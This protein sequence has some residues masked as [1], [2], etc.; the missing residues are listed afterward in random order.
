MGRTSSHA[1]A[2]TRFF[3]RSASTSSSALRFAALAGRGSVSSS[4]DADGGAGGGGGGHFGGR[5][6]V[7]EGI[8]LVPGEARDGSAGG[9]VCR[10]P[11]CDVV[12]VDVC[13][14]ECVGVSVCA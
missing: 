5:R 12:L 11:G 6:D 1:C 10:L 13:V 2:G 4:D 7:G 9:R 14:R 8:V 3:G